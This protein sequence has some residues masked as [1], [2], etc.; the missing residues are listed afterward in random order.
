MVCK[1]SGNPPNARLHVIVSGALAFWE[2]GRVP[3]SFPR[4]NLHP[5][6]PPDK[7]LSNLVSCCGQ[8]VLEAVFYGPR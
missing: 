1:A 3:N 8:F 7:T 5:R 2:S 6:L 4:T